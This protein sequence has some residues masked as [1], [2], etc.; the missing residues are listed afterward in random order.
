M[1]YPPLHALVCGFEKSGTTLLNEILCGHP[2]L[3]AG[4]EVGLLLG[5]SPHE[6]SKIQPY[7]R[8]FRDKWQVSLDDMA[9]I[10]ATDD[11]FEC[12]ARMR[13]RSP[14]IKDKAVSLVD[15]TPI[16]MLHLDEALARVPEIPCVVNVRDPRALMLSW[17]RWSGHRGEEEAYLQR[18]LDQHVARYRTY[19]EGYQL[20]LKHHGERILLNRF[21]LLCLSP[22]TQTKRI[23]DFLGLE[24]SEAY[25]SFDSEHFVYGNEVSSQYLTPYQHVLSKAICDDILEATEQFADWHFS[26]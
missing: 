12:Y 5:E 4:F 22:A 8:Y 20:A 3:D 25:L 17:A 16:Y 24:F 9:W 13:E 26:P 14:I 6:F 10:C 7:F 11:F 21:E 1:N 2:E 19:A 15:K 23:F 18:T